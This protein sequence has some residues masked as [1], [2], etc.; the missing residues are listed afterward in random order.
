MTETPEMTIDP[1]RED[2]NVYVFQVRVQEAGEEE[3]KYGVSVQKAD[4]ARLGKDGETPDQFIA[5]CFE[6]LLEREPMQTI[7]ARFDVSVIPEYFP[8]FEEEISKG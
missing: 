7:L 2:N 5:R 6:F 4:F 8:E 1:V 3:A